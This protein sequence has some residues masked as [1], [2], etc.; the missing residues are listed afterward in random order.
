MKHRKIRNLLWGFILSV[1]ILSPT[2]VWADTPSYIVSFDEDTNVTA[3]FEKKYSL[4]PLTEEDHGI[5]TTDKKNAAR[6]E[7][8]P[9]VENITPNGR[10][11][12]AATTNDPYYTDGSQWAID[13]INASY[14]WEIPA[15]AKP[16]RIAVIDTGFAF[17]HEDA[18][19]ITPGKDYITGGNTAYDHFN[20]GT[21]CAGLIGAKINNG[22]GIAGLTNNCEIIVFS[23]F[24]N[25]NGGEEYADDTDIIAAIYDAV[26]IYHVDVISMS[27][28]GTG[29]NEEMEKA[30]R[31][32]YEKNTI[33]VA[34]SGNGGA[35][36]STYEY[37]AMYDEVV[38]VANMNSSLEINYDSTANDS[39]Y[40][41]APGT[42]IATLD[43]VKNEYCFMSGTSL[44]TP[45]VAALAGIARS[46]D[47]NLTPEGFKYYLRSTSTDIE[48]PGYDIYS[49][50]GLINYDSFLSAVNAN[51]DKTLTGSGTTADPYQINSSADLELFCLLASKEPNISARLTTNITVSDNFS[52]IESNYQG[53]F[54]G[55][56]HTI[57]NLK[58]CL[59]QVIG[60]NGCVKN[61]QISGDIVNDIYN[62]FA[63]NENNGTLEKIVTRGN[64]YV[65]SAGGI[66]GINRGITT[67]CI[68]KATIRGINIGGI[69]ASCRKGTISQCINTAAIRSETNRAA[70]ISS[71][72]VSGGTIKNCYNIG[73]IQG[74]NRYG[75][76]AATTSKQST[77]KNCYYLEGTVPNGGSDENIAAKS[78][79]Y[80]KSKGFLCM[81]NDGGDFFTADLAMKNNGY[82]IF[83][84]SGLTT[85]FNDVPG[86]QWYANAVYDLAAEGILNGKGDGKYDPQASV[87]RAEFVMILAKLSGED[88]TA[89]KKSSHFHDVAAES[90]YN[91]AVNWAEEHKLAY[92]KT[93]TSFYPNDKVTREEIASFLM[94]YIRNKHKEI[95]PETSSLTFSD[96]NRIADW[97]KNDVAS[98]TSLGIIKGYEDFTFRPQNTATRAEAAQLGN[99]TRLKTN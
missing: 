69:A 13:A 78:E 76:I 50:Y 36:G 58:R 51:K 65:E 98:L 25:E 82:P 54:D 38:G 74:T 6:L 85:H 4:T 9:N 5:Y 44:A 26:D 8:N 40:I 42:R 14:G 16:V 92:G 18:G 99:A 7:K 24:Q 96:S 66:C 88:I 43:T 83:G 71:I 70:G 46:I 11:Y 12:L 31:Y 87:T 77:I 86:N 2:G 17:G 56:G 30:A 32:A 15:G 21:A 62:G 81:L 1:C 41:A 29:T 75:G 84:T 34:A 57:S 19:N 89:Y 64:I 90:W 94:R 59:F 37:P 60:E 48:S 67:Q 61:L 91:A 80:M 95:V 55:A 3:A 93:S 20:H 23:V 47:P 49:G 28:G 39:V 35:N 52:G 27:F 68:N 53:T 79:E 97:A 33:L 22:L 10:C 63:A 73:S 45:H 72:L